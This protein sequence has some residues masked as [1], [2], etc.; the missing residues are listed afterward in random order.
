MLAC[1]LVRSTRGGPH[2]VSCARG[3]DLRSFTQG[4]RPHI[5]ASRAAQEPRGAAAG[6][7]RPSI[8]QTPT[9]RR[10]FIAADAA[11]EVSVEVFAARTTLWVPLALLNAMVS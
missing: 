3:H 10:L 6:P 11:S 1:A 9:A 4:E 7:G 5:G 8:R 2:R